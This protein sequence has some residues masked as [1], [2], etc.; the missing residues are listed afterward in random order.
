MSHHPLPAWGL[1]QCWPLPALTLR[2]W[3]PRW[4]LSWLTRAWLP[5]SWPSTLFQPQPP[6]WLPHS[7]PH[8]FSP[9][10]LP[11]SHP[12]MATT[13][14]SI[15][16]SPKALVWALMITFLRFPRGF[17]FCLH[18]IPYTTS[19]FPMTSVKFGLL[20]DDL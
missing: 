3:L 13:A 19:G 5:L 2:S 11:H 15:M 4:L 6:K 7:L 10:G 18:I 20:P 17:L 14:A 12:Q 16:A 8:G 1:P 9:H